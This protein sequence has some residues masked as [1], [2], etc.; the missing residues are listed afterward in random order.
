MSIVC[1][2]IPDNSS[3]LFPYHLSPSR[4]HVETSVRHPHRPSL[5]SVQVNLPSLRDLYSAEKSI[6][7]RQQALIEYIR[8]ELVEV[9]MQNL[10]LIDEAYSYC[11]ILLDL[12]KKY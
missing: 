2:T 3:R 6:F 8:K 4:R 11:Q 10:E 1:L 9:Y 5:P 7:F 12:I